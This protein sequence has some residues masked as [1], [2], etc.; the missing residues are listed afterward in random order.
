MRGLVLLLFLILLAAPASAQEA[1]QPYIKSVEIRG[2][3]DI[4][5]VEIKSIISEI[6]PGRALFFWKPRPEFDRFRVE[7]NIDRLRQFLVGNGYH[8]SSVVWQERRNGEGRAVDIRIDIALGSPV[9]VSKVDISTPDDF[10]D[11]HID[12]LRAVLEKIPLIR[13]KRFSVRR[14]QKAKGVVKRTLLEAGYATASVDSKGE[15]NRADRRA[16]VTFTIDPGRVHTFGN[17][18]IQMS[19]ENLRE[20]VIERISYKTG[21]PSSPAKLIETKRRLLGLGYFESVSI[22]STIDER[23][24]SVNTVIRPVPRKSMTIQFR[25]GA[26]RVDKARG[27]VKFINR[28][29]LNLNRNLELSAWASFASRGAAAVIQQPGIFGESSILSVIFDIRRD[30]F[31]SYNADF[32]IFSTEF[33]K[34]FKDGLLSARF[35]PTFIDSE[36]E[37]YSDNPGGLRGL[38][39]IILVLL[40]GGVSLNA[41]DNQVDPTRG[42]TASLNTELSPSFIGSDEEYF[43]TVFETTGYYDFAGVVM[44]KKFQIGFIENF[45]RT[46]RDDVPP[47]SRLFAGGAKNVRGYSFQTLGDLDAQKN[48]EGGNSL[49]TGSVEARFPLKP[50]KLGGVVFLDYGSVKKRSFDYRFDDLKYAAGFGL[51]YKVAGIPVALDFG[52][53]L[54]H[55]PRLSR[56]QVFLDIG[57]AF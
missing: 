14:F 21:E 30:D 53:A 37:S 10:P 19:D 17:I 50:P 3:G 40:R 18:D 25:A 54:N 43:R 34:D 51:R 15:I 56:Y 39:D 28:N 38:E 44:A 35:S 8:Q 33:R 22:I 16:F 48:P 47:F 49:L 13:G 29:F 45:G 52:Y 23:T 12:S 55:N 6:V 46:S 7:R 4:D 31:P 20:I 5:T 42:F 32:L 27:H 57:Q 26:G 9:V 1:S 41:T 2:N 24:A 11:K 36:I